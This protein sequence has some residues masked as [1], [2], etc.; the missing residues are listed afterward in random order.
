MSINYAL[1]GPG[2]ATFPHNIQ[3]CKRA[4]RWLRKNAARL[5]LDS[6]RIDAIGGSAGGHLTALLAVSG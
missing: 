3:E 6:E 2:A 1:A 5:Q 4:V